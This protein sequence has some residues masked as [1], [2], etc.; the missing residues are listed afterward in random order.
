MKVSQR[1]GL[2][3]FMLALCG[4]LTPKADAS[5]PEPQAAPEKDKPSIDSRLSAVAD[6]L[7]VKESS[8]VDP[9]DTP[10]G[11][12]RVANVFLNF[13]PSFRNYTGGFLNHA[14]PGWINAGTFY[15]SGVHFLNNVPS[16]RNYYGGWIN[17]Y[18]GW[19]N[20]GTFYNS[21]AGF[22]NYNSGFRNNYNGWHNYPGGFVNGGFRNGG[23]TFANGGGGFHNGGGAF[24]NGGGAFANGGGGFR[25]GGGSGAFRNGGGGAFR[26]G[27]GGAFAN[28]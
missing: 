15:N 14:A 22:R 6:A 3:G 23:G 26:N 24:R 25:N 9:L 1:A 19:V 18:P 5:A 28:R 11:P 8:M 7:R 4:L 27:G 12:V 17:R 2:V 10:D 20:H 21:G 13:A 16:F